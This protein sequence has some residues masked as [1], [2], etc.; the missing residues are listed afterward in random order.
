[1]RKS[2]W[3]GMYINYSKIISCSL[4][5]GNLYENIMTEYVEGIS[6]RENRFLIFELE[7]SETWGYYTVSEGRPILT[8][9]NWYFKWL[10]T[11]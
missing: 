8:I 6:R 1:M 5:K 3:Q 9:L 10:N 7:D 4:I 2:Q 11:T